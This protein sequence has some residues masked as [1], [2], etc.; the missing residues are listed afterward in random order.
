MSLTQGKKSGSWAGLSSTS[1][2]WFCHHWAF[3]PTQ[4]VR[5]KACHKPANARAGRIAE[6]ASS[7]AI[8]AREVGAIQQLILMA[9]S[10]NE[11]VVQ[12]ACKILGAHHHPLW[13]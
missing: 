1:Q 4:P 11:V 6:D 3:A 10:D 13:S 9:L 5:M 12:Q 2:R 8:I 7:C